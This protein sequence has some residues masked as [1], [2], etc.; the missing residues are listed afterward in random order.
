[1]TFR[2]ITAAASLVLAVSLVSPVKAAPP[3]PR[4]LEKWRAGG[5]PPRAAEFGPHRAP[6]PPAAAPSGSWNV[7]V[8]CIKFS[9]TAAALPAGDGDEPPANFDGLLFSTGT[10]ATG[11][12]NDYWREVSYGQFGVNGAS[13]HAVGWYTA[14]KTKAES[15]SMSP[16]AYPD[17]VANLVEEA[18]DAAEANGVNFA[19]Y[20]NDGDGNVDGLIV[21]FPGQ[22][23]EVTG[24]GGDINAHRWDIES[25]GGSARAFD[26]KIVNDYVLC[27]EWGVDPGVISGIGVYCHEYGHMLGLPDLYDTD[28]SSN[29]I[30]NYDLM[31]TGLW[32]GGGTQDGTS[33]SHLSAWSKKFLKWVTPTNI[34]ANGAY[35]V[36]QAENAAATDCFYRLWTSGAAGNEYFLVENRQ[37]TGFDADLPGSGILVWHVDE[38]QNSNSNEAHKLVDLEEADG[39]G[40]DA[41]TNRGDAGD[42]FPGTSNN[43]T[44]SDA[45][46]PSSRDYAG[47]PTQVEALAIPVSSAAM[48]VT[49][50]VMAVSPILSLDSRAA[51]PLVVADAAGNGNG[52]AD[53]GE[54]VTLEIRLKNTGLV[55]TGV[56][57]TLATTSSQVT[58][59]DA[60]ASF[61]DM[62]TGTIG[63]TVAPHFAFTVSGAARAMETVPFT[64]AVTSG[65]YTTSLSFD[66]VIGHPKILFV[67]DDLEGVS[68]FSSTQAGI[69]E[70]LNGA[71]LMYTYRDTNAS[72]SPDAAALAGYGVVIWSTGEDTGTVSTATATTLTDADQA[73]LTAYLAGGGNLLLSSQDVAWDLTG[74]VDGAVTQTFLAQY[75]HLS[76]IRHDIGSGSSS[77]VASATAVGRPSDRISTG[78]SASLSYAFPDYSDELTTDGRAD[79]FFQNGSGQV[80]SL[81]YFHTGEHKVVFMTA[82]LEAFPLAVRKSILFKAVDAFQD[83]TPL[84]GGVTGLSATAN[85]D[86]SVT[87]SWA[88]PSDSDF[89][90][91]RIL[92]STTTYPT[93]PFETEP[94]YIGNANTF[95]DTRVTA[96]LPHYYSVFAHDGA[97][98]YSSLS[99]V[100]VVPLPGSIIAPSGLTV[101]RVSNTQVNLRWNDNSDNETG[102]EIEVGDNSTDFFLEANVAEN[103]VGYTYV[104]DQDIGLIYFRVRAFNENCYSEFSNVANSGGGG[105][106]GGGCFLGALRRP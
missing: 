55:A 88:N 12:M 22:G 2:L 50:N 39:G 104:S 78:I 3:H 94:V 54:T 85:S 31:S 81:R 28:M 16:G 32:L 4:L 49:F 60:S 80:T 37:K 86:G 69:L 45:S 56:T 35:T 34:T 19:N 67:D 66:L 90:E 87:L 30:G 93:G 75:L 61:A 24:S 65:A 20:D 17:N 72:G 40:L 26:G 71:G 82:A 7:L 63:T 102:F 1:M 101:E 15:I 105:G 77:E 21:V 23:Q 33:P 29:G 9:D 58:L 98:N 8:I 18:V 42:F 99:Q 51:N 13:S 36:N 48:A 10:Y 5:E 68:G 106:G 27:P 53:P 52:I 6:T 83:V 46:T 25:A 41:K 92:R 74:G 100:Q 43:V 64:L 14:S 47:N 38:T 57:G 70:G 11:S 79:W 91:V 59:T 95:R 97:G 96:W 103:V 89:A 44:F 62:A 76:A 73:A 84:S